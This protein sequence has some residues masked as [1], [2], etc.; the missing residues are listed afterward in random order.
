MSFGAPYTR[1]WEMEIQ[2]WKQHE[3][4]GRASLF[5]AEFSFDYVSVVVSCGHNWLLH[6]AISCLVEAKVG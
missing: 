5:P 3:E 4:Y 1:T 6:L 2:W